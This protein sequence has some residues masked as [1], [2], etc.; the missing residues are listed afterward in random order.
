MNRRIDR[1]EI[2]N[3]F[4]LPKTYAASLLGISISDLTIICKQYGITRWPYHTHKHKM[5]DNSPFGVFRTDEIQTADS[6]FGMSEKPKKKATLCRL[7]SEY[8]FKEEGL[9]QHKPP[10]VEKDS[11]K[12]DIKGDLSFILSENESLEFTDFH[13]KNMKFSKT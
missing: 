1:E 5:R 11:L 7:Q 9:K 13:F 8:N 3:Y 4:K 10:I 6:T 2:E 12:H